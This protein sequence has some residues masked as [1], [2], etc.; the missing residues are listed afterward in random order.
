[1]SGVSRDGYPDA[2]AQRRISF[3]HRQ[4]GVAAPRAPLDGDR[5]ADVAIV[6]GGYTGLWT[7]Y[8]L[9]R[10]KPELEIVVLEREFCGFGAS[11]RNG[12][13]VSS[14]F[15]GSRAKMAE[16]HG[17][18]AVVALQRE[19]Q[20]TIDEVLAVA[21]RERIDADLIKPGMLRVARGPAQLSRLRRQV[22]EDRRW[23]LAKPTS[24]CWTAPRPS[25]G[26]TS[27]E[28]SGRVHP[29]LRALASGQARHRPRARR[30]GA[31]RHAVR[32][33]DRDRRGTGPR[34][35]RSRRGSRRHGADLP[36]GIQLVTAVAAAGDAAAELGDDRHRP[37]AGAS[38][39]RDRLERLRAGRRRRP[40]LHVRAAHGRRPDRARRPRRALPIRLT[41]RQLGP[42]PAADDRRTQRDPALDVPPDG[43]HRDRSSL[44]RRARRPSR[45]DSGDRL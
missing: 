22:A 29:A 45:L 14:A 24:R 20:T 25:A 42:D 31:R 34:E 15:A 28:R 5:T 12:G 36:G 27:R 30:A 9:K 33:H 2:D 19:L 21:E 4:I 37:A 44:V 43:R 18:D 11:G 17:R 7:A 13:W 32:G 8:Y 41:D 6:G 35:H 10:A 23:G 3:W 26:S 39:E 1:M 38:V 16:T 40:R